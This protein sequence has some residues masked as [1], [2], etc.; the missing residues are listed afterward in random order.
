[1]K[2]RDCK[3]SR[4]RRSADRARKLPASAMRFCAGGIG[5]GA[6]VADGYR[7]EPTRFVTIQA[8]SPFMRLTPKEARELADELRRAAKRADAMPLPEQP[9]IARPEPHQW[10]H[11]A[12]GDSLVPPP[13]FYWFESGGG[14]LQDG[15][16]SYGPFPTKDAAMA[17]GSAMRLTKHLLGIIE[18]YEVTA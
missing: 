9:E 16:E 3:N 7:G 5:V 12:V 17:H 14:I 6:K 10:S 11:A 1:M 18:V 13:G 15:R 2:K 8:R 4:T